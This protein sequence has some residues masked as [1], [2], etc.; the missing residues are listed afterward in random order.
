MAT[1][2]E[3]VE[4]GLFLLI[5]AALLFGVLFLLIGLS[6]AQEKDSYYVF[7]TESIGNLKA[8]SPVSF[9]GYPIGEVGDIDL[10]PPGMTEI[11]VELELE[12]G[13]RIT[14]YVRA[15]LKF[16]P[17]TQIYFIELTLDQEGGMYLTPGD[18]IPPKP[19]RVDEIV[20]SIPEMQRNLSALLARLEELLSDENLEAFGSIL[21][22]LDALLED[23]PARIETLETEALDLKKDF[24]FRFEEVAIQIEKTAF[25]MERFAAEAEDILATNRERLDTILTTL[26]EGSGDAHGLLAELRRDPS[27]VFWPEGAEQSTLLKELEGAAKEARELVGLLNEEPSRLI[28]PEGEELRNLLISLEKTVRET[29]SLL[30]DLKRDPSR[31]IWS[32]RAAARKTPD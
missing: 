7:F 12:Q 29:G 20:S 6:L 9:K 11:K 8:N 32:D 26:E 2:R 3:K 16:S 1:R 19:S 18:S 4:A 28:W 24:E 10:V 15:E 14:E 25:R 13:T 22:N 17:L 23:V 27:L 5:C 21:A 30:K 31:I